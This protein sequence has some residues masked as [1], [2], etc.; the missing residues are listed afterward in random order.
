MSRATECFSMNSDMSMRTMAS[1]LSITGIGGPY[2]VNVVAGDY[3]ATALM[4]ALK[5]GLDAAS[6]SDGGVHRLDEQG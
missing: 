5:T 3:T 6:G 1:S 2:T 4:A